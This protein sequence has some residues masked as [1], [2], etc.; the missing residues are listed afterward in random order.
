[1]RERDLLIYVPRDGSSFGRKGG[2]ARSS[3]CPRRPGNSTFRAKVKHA[4]HLF[5][6]ISTLG[7]GWFGGC[8]DVRRPQLTCEFRAGACD[9]GGVLLSGLAQLGQKPVVG[10]TET[11]ALLV[12][13][14][15]LL[16]PPLHVLCLLYKLLESLVQSVCVG[17]YTRERES[18]KE[19]CLCGADVRES[20][21]KGLVL[22]LRG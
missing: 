19:V 22:G 1:M 20:R 12:E 14:C 3:Y 16:R 7:K 10:L 6:C 8:T 5:V 15:V 4:S 2:D 17:G 11:R 9:F 21:R 18:C 13:L